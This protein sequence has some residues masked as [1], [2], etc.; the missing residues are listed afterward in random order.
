MTGLTAA[1]RLGQQGVPAVVYEERPVLGGLASVIQLNGKPLEMF[2]HHW[3]RS[4]RD[5]IDLTSELGLD[6]RLRW[7][8]STVALWHRDGAYDLN[9]PLD[10]A[11]FR[12]LGLVDKI[13]FGLSTLYLQ[14]TTKWHRFDAMTVEEWML[15]WAGRRTWNVVWKPLLEAKFGRF[16]GDISLAW[17]WCKLHLRGASR[18]SSVG[19]E[20]LGYMEGT[21]APLVMD[22]ASRARELGAEIRTMAPVR[23]VTPESSGR[24]TVETTHGRETFDAV[25]NTLAF[26]AFADVA[27]RLPEDYR[28][29]IEELDYIGTVCVLLKNR[30]RFSDIYWQ[31]ISDGSI[32]FCGLIEHTNFIDG[33][34][35]GGAHLLYVANY[36]HRDE[37]LFQLTNRELLDVYYPHLR[38]IN[39]DFDW[40]WVEKA[41][42][43]RAKYAQPI[44][45]RGHKA[46]VPPFRTPVANLWS[47]NMAQVYPEDRGM[48]YAVRS[49]NRVVPEM[50]GVTQWAGT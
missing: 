24:L 8:P 26:P 47:A 7:L 3:F 23:R 32:P 29:T 18:A 15:R 31:N 11:R 13:R 35:Y 27:D 9:T 28:R 42:V 16:A 33:G 49:A 6:H 1:Y 36:V 21:F 44:V 38:R 12:H 10:L 30:H 43:F 5:I 40:S 37:P 19:R 22:L 45:R 2:Y 41:M 48:N 39:P 14:K 4:D 20:C 25:L 17:L 34:D 46:R 50:L